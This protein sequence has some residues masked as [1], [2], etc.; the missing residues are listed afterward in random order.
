MVSLSTNLKNLR[1]CQAAPSLIRAVEQQLEDAVLQRMSTS[2]PDEQDAPGG[3]SGDEST[4]E[5]E[6]RGGGPDLASSVA[7]MVGLRV[8]HCMCRVS[9]EQT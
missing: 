3:S 5:V 9:I 8:F 1:E 6:K 4:E 2:V 7:S